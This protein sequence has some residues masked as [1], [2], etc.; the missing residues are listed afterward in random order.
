MQTMA[1]TIPAIPKITNVDN[2]AGWIKT[3]FIFGTPSLG[4][5]SEIGDS[6]ITVANVAVKG[7]SLV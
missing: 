2:M 6:Q 1:N 4:T 3:T 5:P 7:R